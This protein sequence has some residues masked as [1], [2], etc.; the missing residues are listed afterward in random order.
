MGEGTRFVH[1][2]VTDVR[3]FL[4][5]NGGVGAAWF[6]AVHARVEEQAQ[7]AK[8]KAKSATPKTKEGAS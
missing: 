1:A 4:G 8:S 6:K 7:K 5:L 2:N 3:A